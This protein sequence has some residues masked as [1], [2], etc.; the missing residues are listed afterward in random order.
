[1][2]SLIAVGVKMPELR[3]GNGCVLP[4]AVRGTKRLRPD[5]VKVGVTLCLVN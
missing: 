5:G 1:M 4:Q 2:P 3:L